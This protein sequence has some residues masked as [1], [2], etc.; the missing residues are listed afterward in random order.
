V[1]LETGKRM[2]CLRTDNGGEYVNGNFL[3]FCKHEGITR[4]FIVP[5][6]PQ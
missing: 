2:K 5:H 4:Q 6:M 3:I 1:E